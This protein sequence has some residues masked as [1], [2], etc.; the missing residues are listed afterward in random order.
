MIKTPEELFEFMGQ[1]DY[2]WMDKDGNFHKDITPEMYENYS[3]MSPSEV[4]KYKKGICV[5]QTEF[6]RDWFSKNGYEHKVMNIQI[7]LE[8]ESPG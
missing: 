8:N 3:F 4:L 5:D 6:E 1:I 2:E 7:D